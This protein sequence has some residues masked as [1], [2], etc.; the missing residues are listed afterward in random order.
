LTQGE[1]AE[2]QLCDPLADERNRGEL[3]ANDG[4]EGTF[5]LDWY[6]DVL[7]EF[8]ALSNPDAARSCTTLIT[9][10]AISRSLA[11]TMPSGG[12][13]LHKVIEIA[14]WTMLFVVLLMFESANYP[15]GCFD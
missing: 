11:R 8:R 6:T 10:P 2:Q 4:G 13:S 3:L 14:P 5:N 1:A 15:H 9:M 12:T 7:W